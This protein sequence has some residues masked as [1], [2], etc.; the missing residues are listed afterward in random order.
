MP[1]DRDSGLVFSEQVVKKSRKTRRRDN[2]AWSLGQPPE[3]CSA[4][5]GLDSLYSVALRK[6]LSKLDKLDTESLSTVPEDIL[7]KIWKAIQRS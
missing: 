3:L 5:N 2:P 7:E 6:L 4:G 1:F